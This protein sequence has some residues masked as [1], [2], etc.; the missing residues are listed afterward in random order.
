MKLPGETGKKY[1]NIAFNDSQQIVTMKSSVSTNINNNQTNIYNDLND[2]ISIAKHVAKTECNF[3]DIEL[4][5]I[6]KFWDPIFNKTWIYLS[7]EIVCEDFGYVESKDT[8]KDFHNRYLCKYFEFDIDYKNALKTDQSCSADLPS[9]LTP[10]H[11]GQNK[12]RFVITGETYKQL[13]MLVNTDKG[14]QVRRYYIKVEQLCIK[15]YKIISIMKDKLYQEQ[16][17]LSL[18]QLSIKDKELSIKDKE[19]DIIKKEHEEK[20][21]LEKQRVIDLKKKLAASNKITRDEIIYI[22]CNQS[23][24]SKNKYKVGGVKSKYSLKKRLSSYNTSLPDDDLMYYSYTINVNK[25]TIIENILKQL[26]P[27]L[28]DK[29]NKNTEIYNIYYEDLVNIIDMICNSEDN[30]INHVNTNMDLFIDNTTKKEFIP[31]DKYK[32]GFK[33]K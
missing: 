16:L 7:K 29:S 8:M 9:E 30:Y 22:A 19:L 12:K 28:L 31:Q 17:S 1:R 2:S 10:V 25:Y 4:S 26:I 13:L 23:L 15:T 11:G 21:N 14:K 33:F 3:S 27:N 32:D 24:A 5:Y 18:Q 6:D 20:L